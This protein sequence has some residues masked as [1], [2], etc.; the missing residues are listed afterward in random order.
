MTQNPRV[1]CLQMN[2]T[3]SPPQNI[4]QA[5]ALLKIAADQG[6]NLAITPENTNFIS[7][8]P[9][10]SAENAATEPN[11]T[12]LAKLAEAANIHQIYILIGSILIREENKVYNRSFLVNPQG[13]I[14]A[15]Y[16]KIHLFHATLP[17]GENYRESD[18][19]TPGTNTTL[20]ETPW[21]NVGMSVCYDLRFPQLYRDYARNGADWLAVPSA[22][23][24]PTGRAHWHVLL[25]ARAIENGC[26]VFAPAQTGTHPGGRKTF[27]HSLIVNPWGEI[28]AEATDNTPQC[29]TADINTAAV[30]HARRRIPSLN[31][32]AKAGAVNGSLSPPDISR[33]T[34]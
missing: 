20:A 16:N 15:R 30:Q 32:E 13:E 17:N 28:I 3:D 12:T 8:N 4:S 1:S 11:S 7:N 24:V 6:A 18:T 9:V 29:I 34:A 31:D 26:F 21:A 14:T 10:A 23:T 5:L 27:G 2:G 25:R 19:I 33:A 22:F